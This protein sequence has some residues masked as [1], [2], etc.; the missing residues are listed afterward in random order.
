MERVY[1]VPLRRAYNAAH[2]YRA[3]AAMKALRAFIARHMKVEENAVRID[4]SVNHAI[5]K[6]GARKP[7]R[8]IKVVAV[9][10]ENVVWVYT[11]EARRAAEEKRKKE[12]EVKEGTEKE[13]KKKKAAQKKKAT[14][15]VAQ[16]TREENVQGKKEEK[17]AKNAENNEQ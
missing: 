4:V 12:R 15:E 17:D 11:P 5:W 2:K 7:P 13:S 8:R 1:T 6:R 9:K 16:E 3:R 14:K 10:E